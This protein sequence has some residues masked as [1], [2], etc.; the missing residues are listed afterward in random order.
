[1]SVFHGVRLNKSVTKTR[2][3][4]RIENTV[5]ILQTHVLDLQTNLETS[6]LIIKDK[7]AIISEK[8]AVIMK[9]DAVITKLQARLCFSVFK[10]CKHIHASK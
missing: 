8:D 2:L 5:N 6:H 3:E 7:D 1:V 4:H 9:N 10:T